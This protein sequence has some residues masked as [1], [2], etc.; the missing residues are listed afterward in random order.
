MLCVLVVAAILLTFAYGVALRP[1]WEPEHEDQLQYLTLARGLAERGEFTRA[2]PGEPFIPET[3]RAPGYPLLLAP[4]CRTAGCGHAQIAL[5]QALL[6]G[7]LVALAHDLARR[8]LSRRAALAATALVALYPPFGYWGALALSD[9]PATVLLAAAASAFARAAEG[10][11]ARWGAACGLA[12]GALT[13][14]RP[15]FLLLPLGFALLGARRGL[16]HASLVLLA[17]AVILVPW[18]AY[19]TAT[20]GRPS[21]GNVGTQLWLGYFQGLRPDELDANERAQADEARREIAPFVAQTDRR[22]QA[23]DWL[24]LDDSLRAR[25]L[26]LIA[27]DPLGYAARGAAR[28]FELWAG[29]RPLRVADARRL[30]LEAQV[31]LAAAQLILFAL[32]CAGAVALARRGGAVAAVPLLLLAYVGILSFPAWTE[33]RYALPALP[34]LLIGAVAGALALRRALSSSS[35]R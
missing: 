26:A 14:T 33:A 35:R 29:Q 18:A 22:A 21:G 25:A 7:A 2:G 17:A 27:H 1:E 13:L 19:N 16:R 12:L 30:P 15:F 24:A 32:G 11:S 5:A 28:S 9:L 31:A 34:A 23:L 10:T 8:V 3:L 6:A 4:L 20:F